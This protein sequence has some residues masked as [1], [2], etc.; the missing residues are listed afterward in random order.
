MLIYIS[1]VS[2]VI[3]IILLIVIISSKYGRR[4]NDFQKDIEKRRKDAI[5]SKREINKSYYR[6]YRLYETLPI[7]KSLIENLRKSL[8]I[9]GEKDKQYL[10]K[11][12]TSIITGLLCAV[13]IMITVFWQITGSLLY[14]VVF[15]IFVWYISDS[16][17]DYFISNSHTR[18]LTQMLEFISQVRQKYYEYLVVDDAVYEAT[19]NLGKQSREMSVQGE[20]IY[21]I[22]MDSNSLEA[23]ANYMEIAPNPFLKM[24]V[25][26]SL[27]TMEYGDSKIQ[28]SSV[29]LMNLSFLTKN[30][31]L[32]I[33]KRQR[34]NYALKSM[35]FIV[36]LPLLFINPLKDWSINNFAPLGK[37]YASPTGKYVEIITLA[38][39]ILS[40]ILLNKIQNLDNIKRTSNRFSK[41]LRAV[42]LNLDYAIRVKWLFCIGG[43][44]FTMILIITVQMQGRVNLKEKVYYSDTFMGGN[45]TE[46]EITKRKQESIIDYSFIKNSSSFTGTKE[47]DMYLMQIGTKDEYRASRIN[48]KVAL[49]HKYSISLWQLLVCLLIGGISYFIPEINGYINNKI[50]ALDVEDEV[51]GFRSII[52]MLMYNKRMSVEEVIEWMEVYALYY[53]DLLHK[54][55]L[56]IST[57]EKEAIEEMQNSISNDEM[58]RL[59]S[60]LA[61]ASEDISLLEAFDELVQEKNNFFEKRK[62]KNEKLVGRKVLIGQNIGFLPTYSLIIFYMIIPMIMSS[63]NELGRFFTQ[64]M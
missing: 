59:T 9:V 54:C 63:I 36:M 1:M 6:L 19:Q 8:V 41:W 32:E 56:N 16:Y 21:N 62:W 58:L 7:I 60:Q 29:Y 51:A 35:N 38:V 30:I 42:K 40:M 55:L 17:L 23:L 20:M 44:V 53:K 48:E 49:Y 11:K 52:M 33:D 25:N 43:F 47:I 14:T 3:T 5:G 34:L 4:K 10:I 61:M 46:E 15:M 28:G 26:F 12:T 37:F 22:F 2:I 50:R 45:F 39:I 64:V 24:F 57:G 18:L 27:L 13:A 31:Q